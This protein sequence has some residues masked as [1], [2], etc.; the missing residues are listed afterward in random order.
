MFRVF[1]SSGRTTGFGDRKTPAGK[2]QIGKGEQRKELCSV[3]GQAAIPRFSMTKQVLDDMKRMFDFR[4]DASLQMLQLFRQAPQFIVGTSGTRVRSAIQ[5]RTDELSAVKA[6]SVEK[7]IGATNARPRCAELP[8]SGSR[9]I[10]RGGL[11]R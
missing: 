7:L 6:G 1:L 11:G 8:R 2:Q 10:I 3:F 4:P 9:W 5:T